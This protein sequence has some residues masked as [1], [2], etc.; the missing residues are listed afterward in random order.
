MDRIVDLGRDMYAFVRPIN[1]YIIM[2]VFNFFKNL[3][4]SYGIV[5]LLLTLFIRL[6]TSAHWYTAVI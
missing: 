2:P 5:I 3:V 1:T 4:S 6:L